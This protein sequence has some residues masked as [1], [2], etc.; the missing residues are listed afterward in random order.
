MARRCPSWIAREDL[1]SAGLARPDR[2][3]RPLRR[4]RA[5]S[6]SSRS[7]STGSAAPSWTS[8]AAATSCRAAFASSRARSATAIRELEK[9]SGEAPTD[10]TDRRRARRLGRD[11][12]TGPRELVPCRGR[13]ARST[14][15]ARASPIASESRP[16]S[17]PVTA[18]RSRACARRSRASSSATSRSSACTTSRTSRIRRSRRRCGITPSRVCQLLWR[19]VERLRAQLGAGMQMRAAAEGC[20][21]IRVM[22][23]DDD[24][25]VRAHA[26][27]TRSARVGFDV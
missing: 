13:V 6:R 19:A 2:G 4:H 15:R 9:T 18:R 27:R 20:M 12:R 3:R 11:Y 23:V 8:C 5:R 16:T 25:L 14:A 22:I 17:K 7:P 1:V 26:C 21:S 10:Q 24:A